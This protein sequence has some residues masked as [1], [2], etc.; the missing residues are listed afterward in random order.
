M[1]LSKVAQSS[2]DRNSP[3]ATAR[4]YAKAGIPV[5]PC[6]NKQPLT[7]NGFHDATTDL[8]IIRLW[9]QRWPGA[10]VATPTGQASGRIILDLDNRT[11]EHEGRRSLT[12]L[13]AEYGEL[14]DTPEV[15]T[16]SGGAH[17]VFKAP[18]GVRI[19]CSA[20]KLGTGIDVRGDGGY[21]LI[22]GSAGYQWEAAHHPNDI[23][24]ADVPDWLLQ[25][26]LPRGGNGTPSRTS[27]PDELETI[28]QGRRNSTMT[29]H[30]GRLRSLGYSEA[31]IVGMLAV[32]NESRCTPPLDTDEIGR[33]ARSAARWDQGDFAMG[34]DI[35]DVQERAQ[36]SATL[37][38]A[39]IRAMAHPRAR[40]LVTVATRLAAEIT[41]RKEQGVQPDTTDGMYYISRDVLGG[42]EFGT[43]NWE[44]GETTV[45]N[46]TEELREYA[47]HIPGFAARK[48]LINFPKRDVDP[49]TG[50][51]TMVDRYELTWCYNFDGDPAQIVA[52]LPTLPYPED[53]RGKRCATCGAEKKTKTVEYCPDCEIVQV[54]PAPDKGGA[55]F[56]PIP[57]A[58]DLGGGG[59]VL[60]PIGS[61]SGPVPRGAKFA[62]PPAP[63]SAWDSIYQKAEE[64]TARLASPANPEAPTCH[65]TLGGCSQPGHCAGLGRCPWAP[66]VADLPTPTSTNHLGGSL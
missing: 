60:A 49:E 34:A 58:A 21:V 30:A 22:P 20:G 36:R 10:D 41:R 37:Q 18:P 43:D 14:P 63:A 23:P 57:Q 52:A 31:E 2:T 47:P 40:K 5:F 33:I 66:T 16:P 8:A 55:K 32:L 50:E 45:R 42:H 46:H 7:P 44:I 26:I 11:G 29:S 24:L 35:T 48:S 15:I 3:E 54:V 19:P 56:A 6:R 62:P 25:R 64:T 39:T 1:T 4:R 61:N 17:I 51:V 9:W 65:S 53:R 13:E 28:P 59:Q 12:A 38:S 27:G